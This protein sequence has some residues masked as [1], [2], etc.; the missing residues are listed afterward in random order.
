MDRHGFFFLRLSS[1][2]CLPSELFALWCCVRGLFVNSCS[3]FV[4]C[5]LGGDCGENLLASI[6]ILFFRH[7]YPSS[8]GTF[9]NNLRLRVD[10]AEEAGSHDHVE[11]GADHPHDKID[12]DEEESV[13]AEFSV[14]ARETTTR[15]WERELENSKEP[16]EDEADNGAPPAD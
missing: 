15:R 2:V 6:L 1:N 3:C 12:Y 5:F 9:L 10:V 13:C 7:S 8:K 4:C 11:H 14:H 16:R